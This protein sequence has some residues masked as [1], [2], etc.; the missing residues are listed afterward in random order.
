MM[1]ELTQTEGI[2]S[3]I[4]TLELMF[5]YKSGYYHR[6]LMLHCIV[7]PTSWSL[8]S[9]LAFLVAAAGTAVCS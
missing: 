1:P 6:L 4:A 5:A 8:D 3:L 9:L 7:Q 2:A